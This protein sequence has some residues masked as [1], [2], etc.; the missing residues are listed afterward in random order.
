[1]RVEEKGRNMNKKKKPKRFL[2][3]R[4][5]EW[6]GQILNI[7]RNKERKKQERWERIL[8]KKRTNG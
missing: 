4:K 3:R 1:M 8:K 2:K 5:L 6:H 7:E